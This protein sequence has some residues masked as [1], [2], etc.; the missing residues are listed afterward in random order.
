L[1]AKK[2]PDTLWRLPGRRLGK[3]CLTPLPQGGGKK[4]TDTAAGKAL[5]K[6]GD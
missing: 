1:T 6:K 4:V 5:G 3:E 2:V